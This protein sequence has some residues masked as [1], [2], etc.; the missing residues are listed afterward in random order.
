MAE[1]RTR[2]AVAIV[3]AMLACAANAN[4]ET[5]LGAGAM[6]S[7]RANVPGPVGGELFAGWNAAFQGFG[8]HSW[9]VYVPEDVGQHTIAVQG[10]MLSPTR[11]FGVR[12]RFTVSGGVATTWSFAATS[13]TRVQPVLSLGTLMTASEHTLIGA[14]ANVF[15]RPGAADDKTPSSRWSGSIVVL[16]RP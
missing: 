15:A 12:L 16:W 8:I 3:V 10:A 1:R 13:S 4:A 6:F 9:Y 5:V 14:S 7:H 11:G 2:V